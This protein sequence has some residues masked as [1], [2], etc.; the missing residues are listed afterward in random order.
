M[1]EALAE[2]VRRRAGRACEYCRMQ[3]A[4]YPTIPFPIDHVIARQHGG[5][6]AQRDRPLWLGAI[7]CTEAESLNMFGEAHPLGRRL[8]QLPVRRRGGVVLAQRLQLVK[9]QF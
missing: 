5:A 1:D 9:G 4:F 3:Q 7:R 6:T 8:E 2:Q